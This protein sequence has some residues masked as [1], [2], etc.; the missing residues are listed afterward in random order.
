MRKLTGRYLLSISEVQR[1]TDSR[2]GQA[3]N[4][5]A[6]G[7][8]LEVP[9]NVNATGRTAI[10]F[11]AGLGI[12]VGLALL[13]APQSGQETREWLSETAE[14]EMRRLKRKGRRSIENIQDAVTRGEQ[15]VSKV[16]RSGKNVLDSVASK[17]D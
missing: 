6:V 11:L 10:C 9:M 17:L 15:T 16:L 2:A 4:N 13:F 8:I 5:L 12:G 7:L 1:I 3:P 14:D